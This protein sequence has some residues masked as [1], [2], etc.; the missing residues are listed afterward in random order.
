MRSWLFWDVTQLRLFA[1]VSGQL[2]AI[3]FLD[4][5]TL[6][7][8]KDRLSRNVGNYQSTL[9]NIPEE[10]RSNVILIEMYETRSR[11]TTAR[12]NCNSDHRAA[13]PAK[14]SERGLLLL[15]L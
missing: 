13:L 8:W 10:G 6:E 2:I 5:L 7:N 12:G 11:H 3:I 4:F 9:R 15:S 14:S 1:D